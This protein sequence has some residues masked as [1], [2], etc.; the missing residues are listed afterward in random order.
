M[1]NEKELG[2]YIDRRFTRALFR[3][4]IL[5][6]Y[7][8]SSNGDE[9]SRYIAGETK[10]NLERNKPWMEHIRGEVARGLHTY[11]VHVVRSPL[12][13]YLRF[14]CE[15]GYV[16]NAQAGEHI[17]ILDLAERPRPAELIDEDFW[18]I[19]EREALR[20][21]YS[22]DGKYVGA[23]RTPDEMLPRYLAAKDAAWSGAVGFADYWKAHPG[24][25]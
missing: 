14:E 5:D 22:E 16:Y 4:E 12:N 2:D 9:Y 20:M 17:R 25:W 8:V 23:E 7:D 11:R 10:P 1:L 15:W 21:H 3:L 18:L 19:D 13:D 24:Y 6:L